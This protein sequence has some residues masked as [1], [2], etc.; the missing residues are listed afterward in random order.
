MKEVHTCHCLLTGM[1]VKEL[2]LMLPKFGSLQ[3]C[4]LDSDGDGRRAREDFGSGETF[5]CL[6]G[7]G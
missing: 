1:G 4:S 5:L 2:T 7:L 6:L 3:N